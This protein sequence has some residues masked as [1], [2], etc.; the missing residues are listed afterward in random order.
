MKQTSAARGKYMLI[1]RPSSF[2]S[3]AG[4]RYKQQAFQKCLSA[5][6]KPSICCF[7]KEFVIGESEPEQGENLV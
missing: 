4:L 5:L 2:L 6:R 1:I 7:K 3:C